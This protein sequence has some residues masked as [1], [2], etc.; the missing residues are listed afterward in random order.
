MKKIILNVIAIVCFSFMSN[1]NTNEIKESLNLK[2]ES[3]RTI[4]D[5]KLE[6]DWYWCVKFSE[7]IETN[8]MDG[9]ISTTTTYVCTKA[10]F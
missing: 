6:E 5:N 2:V 8:E 7:D 1:A 9:S 10:E 4:E 3:V